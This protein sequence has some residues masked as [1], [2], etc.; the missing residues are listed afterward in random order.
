MLYAICDMYE[1]VCL[2]IDMTPQFNKPKVNFT[3]GVHVV[4]AQ[5]QRIFSVLLVKLSTLNRISKITSNRNLELQVKIFMLFVVMINY[6]LRITWCEYPLS[7]E[8]YTGFLYY[9]LVICHGKL[10]MQIPA[11]FIYL[12]WVINF[13]LLSSVTDLFLILN[14][15]HVTLD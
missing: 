14:P 15:V 5:Q 1:I 11:L 13:V 3:N 7:A 12:T 9:S 4:F 2:Q 6:T 8:R 10:F